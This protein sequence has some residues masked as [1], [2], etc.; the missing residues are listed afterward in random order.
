MGGSLNEDE[1]TMMK[2]KCPGIKN[3]VET[4]TY[5]C[6]T[7]FAAAKHYDK[8]YTT[9]IVEK[10]YSDGKKMAEA[11]NI[12]NVD[13]MLGDSVE[14]LD[15]IMPKVKEGAVFYLD[16][17]QSGP[18]TGNNQKQQV[19]LIEELEKIFSYELGPSVFI[20]DDLRFWKDKTQQAWDWEHIST[21]GII[22]MFLKN[23]KKVDD[24]YEDNDRF[25]VITK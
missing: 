12:L 10:L 13:F 19:P 23:N 17:H 7:T 3:F 11:L 25:W 8:V 16:A 2:R 24:F 4:G 6:D 15:I 1:F 5:K 20:L 18:D 14:L 22:K 21:N 9:E